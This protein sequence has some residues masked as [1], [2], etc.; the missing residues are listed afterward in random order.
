MGRG[1]GGREAGRK[2]GRGEEM[3]DGEGV[4]GWKGGWWRKCEGGK[5]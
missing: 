1:G 2:G 4:D 3:I 5:Y